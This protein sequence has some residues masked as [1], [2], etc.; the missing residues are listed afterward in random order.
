MRDEH[1]TL[2]ALSPLDGRYRAKV[3]PLADHF[4]EFA[5]IRQRVRVEI[6]W[7]I[8]LGDEPAIPEV[9]RFDAA[10]RDELA[11]MA[12]QFA[13]ADAARVKEIERTTNHD[14]K[15]VEYWL[16]ERLAGAAGVAAHVEFIHFACTSED[17]NNLAHGIALSESRRDIVLP[18]LH[19]IVAALRT[20]AHDH[21]A[22]PMLSRTHGQP[23]SPTTLGKEMA[24]VVARLDR[25]I[26]TLSRVPM[27]GKMNGA[28]GNYNAHVAAYPDVDWER[29]ATRVVTSLGL[30]V[31]PY[32]TQIEPHDYI[33]EYCDALARANTI[34]VDL[35]RDTW[36]YI[37]VG[38]FRQRLREGEVGSSTMPHKVNPIDFENAEGNL[39]LSNALL[40]HL[41]EKLPISRWQ[42][43]LTDST[44]LRNLGVALG[45]A[46]L[47]WTSLQQG[48]GKLAVDPARLAA[49]LEANWEV[50]AEAIQTV[51]RRYGLPE[52]YEQL[53][54]LTRGRGI[55]RD[56]LRAFIAGL[57]LPDDA[58]SRLIDLTP[59]TYVGLAEALARRV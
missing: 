7:L 13:P 47:G 8:A 55:T 52:P 48:L 4:S 29:L 43:D 26:T 9:P 57:A 56:S 1:P 19:A 16:K 50:L 30:E 54:A 40:R 33:A 21:A 38:Y 36:G 20:L 32:T 2:T 37:G 27:K 31:N 14:V 22:A 58:K 41:A 28:V 53:K 17:V 42:R 39:G 24:N 34:L 45:H 23:A 12:A 6:A 15:A 5:L 44:V 10:L 49:D 3:A 51:M 18:A 46:L 25:A 59:A 11:R 35:C